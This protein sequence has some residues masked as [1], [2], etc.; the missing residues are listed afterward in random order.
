MLHIPAWRSQPASQPTLQSRSLHVPPSPQHLGTSYTRPP[1]HRS[2]SDM[3]GPLRPERSHTSE[4]RDELYLCID[5]VQAPK[6]LRSRSKRVGDI[7]DG[8]RRSFRYTKVTVLSMQ[9]IPV[10]A[11]SARAVPFG[12]HHAL[13][14][15][16]WKGVLVPIGVFFLF[17]LHMANGTVIRAERTIN[18]GIWGLWAGW[19]MSGLSCS[20]VYR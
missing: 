20:R 6:K 16:R 19:P 2:M 4:A 14:L 18:L 1:P 17:L 10:R 15:E 12:L 5:A 8:S 13:I 7:G 9:S 11:S 3:I